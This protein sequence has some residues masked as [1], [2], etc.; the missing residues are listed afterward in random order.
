[1]GASKLGINEGVYKGY[2][3]GDKREGFG[4]F[5]SK[6]E[7]WE[8]VWTQDEM[9][10]G[11]HYK[12]DMIYEG[13]FVNNLLEGEATIYNQTKLE[14]YSAFYKKGELRK[15][16]VTIGYFNSPE[17]MFQDQNQIETYFGEINH[18]F[19]PHG[20]GRMLS[21]QENLIYEGQFYDGKRQG[22]GRVF[23]G[24]N[25]NTYIGNWE[26]GKMEGEGLL[27]N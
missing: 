13:N 5:E 26:Y 24:S 21:K 23:Y 3:H 17:N 9:K 8:G 10:R 22:S 16:N 11:K 15:G 19:Q 20:K 27:I 1:M 25:G 18:F 2:W 12:Q 4:N 7:V 6:E 14:K